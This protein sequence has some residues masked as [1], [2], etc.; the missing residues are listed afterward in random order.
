MK[1]QKMSTTITIAISLVLT[2]CIF[3]LCFIANS[4]M[5]AMMKQSE[6]KNLHAS[7]SAQSNLIEEYLTHQEDLLIAFSKAPEIL[8]LLKEPTNEEKLKTVQKYTESYF[9]DLDNWEGLYVAE[10]DSHVIAHSNPGVVGIT[11]RKGD[12]LKALQ[13]ALQK[14]N[15][16]YNAGIIVSPASQKMVLSLYCPVFDRDGKTIVGFVGGAQFAESLK[17]V[18]AFMQNGEAK[19]SMLNA[20]TGMYIFDEDD[21]LMA[22]EI[23]NEMLLSII[24]TIQSEENKSTGDKEYVDAKEGKSLAAYEY[25]PEHNWVIVSCDSENNI[26]AD[27]NANTRILIVLCVVFDLLIGFLSW[28]LIRISTRPLKNVEKS[29]NQLKELKLEKMHKLDKYINGKSE[30]GQIATAIDSLYDSF[31]NIASTL[32]HCSESLTQSAV[33]MSDSSTVLIQC[34]EENSDTTEEFAKHTESITNT[35]ERVDS[36]VGEIANVVS[37][38]KSKIQV[39]TERSDELSEQV[40]RMRENVS[41][42]LQATGLRI[43][44]NKQ[45][46]EEAMQNLQSLTRIDE[47]AEQILDITSQTN[48]LS[49]NASIEAARAGEAGRGFAVVAGEIG[50][51]ASSSSSTA[52]EIQNICNETKVNIAKIQSCFDSIVTFLQSDIQVQFEDF[53]KAT[54]EYY[55]SI[56]E[57][58]TIIKDVEQASNVFVDVVASIRSQIDAVQ[59]IPGNAVISTEDILAKVEQIEKVTEELSVIV[60]ANQ[61]NAISI[62]EI[63]DR[64]CAY[65]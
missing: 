34:V 49:L 24:S 23:Q 3:M 7:L 14:E 21:S 55:Q 22:T 4:R 65:N 44:E 31:R 56:E 2:V 53:A 10:W 39:G 5:M 18:L 15:G 8:D 43:E 46:I 48:L 26:Y 40:Y 32:N 1:N 16:I 50:N 38:V 62:R 36:E 12:G 45:A 28:M 54:N 25:I 52:T 13:E 30:I 9:A 35:V 51:L 19:Y 33:K 6:L 59:N 42:S 64:F 41:T 63:V 37:L 61:D 47:M 29:I 27:A 58:Q 11:T 20:E 17:N 60:K 57:I